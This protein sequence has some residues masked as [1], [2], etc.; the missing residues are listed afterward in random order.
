MFSYETLLQDRHAYLPGEAES[1]LNNEIK[2]LEVMNIKIFY[3]DNINNF[4]KV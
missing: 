2:K 1:R 3:S 4:D